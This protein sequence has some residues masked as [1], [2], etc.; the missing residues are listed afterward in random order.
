MKRTK[1]HKLEEK[2]HSPFILIGISYSDS[3]HKLAW[4]L[5]S[6]SNMGL[7]QADSIQQVKEDSTTLHFPAMNNDT[8][9]SELMLALIKCKHEG[10]ALLKSHPN[11]DYVIQ[12]AG[13]YSDTI[14]AAIR[15]ELKTIPGVM[16]TFVISPKEAKLKEPLSPI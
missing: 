11:I 5:N 7:S 1:I 14:I 9:C 4:A 12:I 16:A 6:K 15:R 2:G 3:I 8:E 10:F 13:T